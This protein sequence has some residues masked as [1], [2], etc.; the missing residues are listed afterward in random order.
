M[1]QPIEGIP[2]QS[3]RITNRPTNHNA[4]PQTPFDKLKNTAE[5]DSAMAR[6]LAES[7]KTGRQVSIFDILNASK[8]DKHH[9]N[10]KPRIGDMVVFNYSPKGHDRLPYWDRFPLIF[11]VDVKEDRFHGINLHYLPPIL[12]LKLIANLKTTNTDNRYDD[13]TRIR[14]N[15]KMLKQAVRF[16]EFAPCYKEYVFHGLKSRFIKVHSSE[17]DIA[18]L[19]PVAQFAH[20][21]PNQVFS[22]SVKKIRK[23]TSSNHPNNGR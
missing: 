3:N 7:K 17:W 8:E 6:L 23:F 9:S 15:Y 11:I 16:R 18:S 10:I 5:I 14:V 2:G 13:K 19:L 1:K 12:R 4:K 20:K 21:Q 22:E